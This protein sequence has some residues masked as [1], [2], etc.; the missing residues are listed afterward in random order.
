MHETNLLRMKN[1]VLNFA[2]MCSI[3]FL[4]SQC[5][6][7]VSTS[8]KKPHK[9]VDVKLSSAELNIIPY[10]L[11]DSVIFKDSLGN[12]QILKVTRKN[13][14]SSLVSCPKDDSTD[15]FIE[16]LAI[17]LSDDSNI[18]SIGLNLAPP[19]P[20]IC[21]SANTNKDYF[22][23][24]FS[25]PFSHNYFGNGFPCIIDT[26]NF[27]HMLDGLPI[28]YYSSLTLVN[29]TFSSVYELT[30]Q[31]SIN[32]DYLQSVYYNKTKG[33][34]GFQMKSGVKWYLAN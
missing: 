9:R 5:S 4:F 8:I 29:K 1:N 34:V 24:S 23:V 7:D 11:N 32:A 17:M 30:H 10:L 2:L 15:Y 16:N 18:N 31:F 6:K 26:T 20:T 28:P 12:S 3:I 33:I 13:I 14:H 25:T 22:I 21:S 27:Y 19:S